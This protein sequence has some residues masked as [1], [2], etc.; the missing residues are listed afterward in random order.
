MLLSPLSSVSHFPFGVIDSQ[1]GTVD[2]TGHEET[3]IK[4]KGGD[5]EDADRADRL[6]RRLQRM[7]P[8]PGRCSPSRF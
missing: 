2:V 5:G 4:L 8:E 7:D 1:S 3:E 6:M